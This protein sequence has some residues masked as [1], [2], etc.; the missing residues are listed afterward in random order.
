MAGGAFF[1]GGSALFF[2]EME[3]LIM[4][5]GWRAGRPRVCA[6]RKTAYAHLGRRDRAE[7]RREQHEDAA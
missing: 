2:P 7:Q 6:R 5:G 4:H 1:V 3:H